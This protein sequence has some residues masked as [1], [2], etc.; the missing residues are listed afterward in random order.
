MT[1]F[2][3]A[4]GAARRRRPPPPQHGRQDEIHSS[5]T[6]LA[7]MPLRRRRHLAAME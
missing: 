3:W 4:L 7:Q 5:G 6:L 1:R 2:C